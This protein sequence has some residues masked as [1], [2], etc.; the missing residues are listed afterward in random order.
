MTASLP[1]TLLAYATFKSRLV[2]YV[3]DIIIITI[4]YIVLTFISMLMFIPNSG[5]TSSYTPAPTQLRII[6][7]TGLIIFA[8]YFTIMHGIFNATIGKAIMKI[9][10]RKYDMSHIGVIEAF[11]RVV[12][13]LILETTRITFTQGGALHFIIMMGFLIYCVTSIIFIFRDTHNRAVHD[14]LASTI[15]IKKH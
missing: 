12:P 4:L 1:K 7:F 10:V 11:L 3:I 2:A 14:M 5:I 15:V 9:R 13:L 6:E 8:L